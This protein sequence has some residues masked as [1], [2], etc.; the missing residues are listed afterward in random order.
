[1]INEMKFVPLEQLTFFEEYK[2]EQLIKMKSNISAQKVLINTPVV[3]RTHSNQYLILDGTHRV[4]A[5]NELGCMNITVQL[6]D[7]KS[8]NSRSWLHLIPKSEEIITDLQNNRNFILSRE[9]LIEKKHGVKVYIED[10]IYYIYNNNSKGNKI[11]EVISFLN[12]IIEVYDGKYGYKKQKK[13]EYSS[14]SE[15]ITIEF[16]EFTKQEI[17]KYINNVLFPA[18][19]IRFTSNIKTVKDVMIPISVIRSPEANE[20]EWREILEGLSQPL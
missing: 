11:G 9:R 1:M 18:N 8:V 4:L 6:I 10:Q 14:N 17:I 7:E 5:L 3:M 15:Y 20:F 19:V 2:E 16:P 13:E 12:S